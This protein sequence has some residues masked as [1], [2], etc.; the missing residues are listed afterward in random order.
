MVIVISVTSIINNTVGIFLVG[1]LIFYIA[2]T[3]IDFI[4]AMRK[5]GVECNGK[6]LSFQ[7]GSDGYKN[8]NIEFTT[9][10]G[11]LITG[12]PTAYASTDLSKFRSYKN[13]IGN[14]VAI[15]YDPEKPDRFII[16]DET[17]FTFFVF[18]AILLMSL[19]CIL[20]CLYVFGHYLKM[21]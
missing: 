6:Y 12:K 17:A 21:F 13:L 11:E 1:L 20:H 7:P 5:R 10:S 8:P 19:A 16:A 14:E 4:L 2:V 18:I 9:L 15:L 3:G